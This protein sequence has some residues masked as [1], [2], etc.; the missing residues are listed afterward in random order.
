MAQG[1][2]KGLPCDDPRS[3]KPTTPRP[4]RAAPMAAAKGTGPKGT[5]PKGSGRIVKG[6]E[7]HGGAQ[8]PTEARGAAEE[9]VSVPGGVCDFA[10][11]EEED[12]GHEGALDHDLEHRRHHPR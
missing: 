9:R 7:R 11:E 1:C 6:G 8:G 5:G 12:S 3:G 2:A 10:A 4:Y